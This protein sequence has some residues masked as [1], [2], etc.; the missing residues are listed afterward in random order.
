MCMFIL[1]HK[2][3]H[4]RTVKDPRDNPAQIYFINEKNYGPE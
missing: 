2:S 3:Y 4:F 1:N